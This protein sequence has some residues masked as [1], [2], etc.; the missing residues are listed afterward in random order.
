M[1]EYYSMYIYIYKMHL[2][3]CDRADLCT[4]VF[5]HTTNTSM[6]F[7]QRGRKRQM[8]W[9]LKVYSVYLFLYLFSSSPVQLLT[10]AA[11][12][13]P[14]QSRKHRPLNASFN[15]SSTEGMDTANGLKRRT[16]RAGE[17]RRETR[18]DACETGS[19]SLASL[20]GCCLWGVTWLGVATPPPPPPHPCGIS[21]V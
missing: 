17:T 11:N 21:L 7:H 15:A 9:K 6:T 2:T 13:H 18:G 14:A 1:G 8:G 19:P 12:R 16:Q 5:M 20:H 3:G 10:A 4:P